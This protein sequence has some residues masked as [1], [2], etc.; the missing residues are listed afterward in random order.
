MLLYNGTFYSSAS[1]LQM[2]KFSISILKYLNNIKKL[3]SRVVLSQVLF[4]KKY[5]YRCGEKF[6]FTAML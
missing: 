2:L 1:G 6:F 3:V 5:R 4:R